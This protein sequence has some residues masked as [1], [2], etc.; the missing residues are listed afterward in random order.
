MPAGNGAGAPINVA[1]TG[2]EKSIVVG[3]VFT[4][5][6]ITVEASNDGGTT[7]HAVCLFSAPGKRVVGVAAQF[8]RVFVRG[9]SAEPFSANAD[10]GANDNGA[11]FTILPVPAGDGAGAPVDVS[12]FGNFTTFIAGGLFRDATISIEVSEDGVDYSPCG[13]VFSGQGGLENKT[14]VGNFMRTFVRGRVGN[15][16]PFTPV[17]A[18]G[19]CND[20]TSAMPLPPPDAGIATL[21]YRETSP[22]NGPVVFGTWAGLMSRLAALKAVSNGAGIY[23][24]AFD[25]SLVAPFTGVTIPAAGSPHD[26]QGVDWD[27]G[28]FIDQTAFVNIAD[29]A[30]FTKLRKINGRMLV[31]CLAATPSPSPVSDFAASLE[32]VRISGGCTITCVGEPMFDFTSI[33][34]GGAFADV[35]MRDIAT[36]LGGGSVPVI[37]TGPAGSTIQVTADAGAGFLPGAIEGPAGTAVSIAGPQNMQYSSNFP[38]LPAG[39]LVTQVRNIGPMGSVEPAPPAAASTTS[40]ASNFG[41]TVQRFDTSGGPIAQPLPTLPVDSG[42]EGGRARLITLLEESGSTGLTATAAGGNTING[43]ATPFAIPAGGSA[44]FVGDGDNNWHV[45]AVYDPADLPD[46]YNVRGPFVTAGP[47]SLAINDLAQADTSGATPV[48]TLPAISAGNSGCEVV[49]KKVTGGGSFD[50]D[51]TGG[52]TVDGSSTPVSITGALSS[53]TLVSDGVS[54]WMV[55]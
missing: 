38:G 12:A 10:V 24:I 8:L 18:V 4:G 39:A 5:A 50:V 23:K 28:D 25:D 44:T 14:V 2:Q 17:I 15:T 43:S 16:F 49:I 36:V 55:I 52:D 51:G 1:A 3:G 37:R 29:G 20:P 42:Q 40:F 32:Q 19:A 7:F 41:S 21:I 35:Y 11:M 48:F 54:N 34:G 31:T 27:N 45:V 13:Q 9:R 30:T 33:G 46:C 6:T 26:M 22:D 53:V 47:H